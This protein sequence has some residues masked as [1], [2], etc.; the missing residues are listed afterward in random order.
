MT[1]AVETVL[2]RVRKCLALADASKGTPEGDTAARIARNIMAQHAIEEADLD[3]GERAAQDPIEK[4]EMDLG[5]RSSWRRT[6]AHVLAKHCECRSAF[7]ANTPRVNVYGHKSSID[8]C[9]YLYDICARQIESES[10][11]YVKD[12]K[13][14][15]LHPFHGGV[16][17]LR[18]DFCFSAVTSLAMRLEKMRR[19]E[20]GDD[21]KGHALVLQRGKDVDAWVEANTKFKNGRRH[22]Y[23]YS[24]AGHDAGA[25]VSLAPGITGARAQA[26]G[27]RR[28]LPGA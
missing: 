8:V 5:R 12:V 24:Q 7:V 15:V 11:R 25:K 21:A 18:N 13:R 1:E 22:T 6:L 17:R 28:L 4:R 20:A 9:S 14:G 27:A 2:E 26:A 19:K 3:V 16:K 23:G 10:D